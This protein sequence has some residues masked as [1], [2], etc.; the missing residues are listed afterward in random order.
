MTHGLHKA[1][2]LCAHHSLTLNRLELG[3]H[4]PQGQ[5]VAHADVL[6]SSKSAVLLSLAFTD[7]LRTFKEVMGLK[8]QVGGV[9]R[10]LACSVH[11][12]KVGCSTCSVAAGCAHQVNH[13]AALPSPCMQDRLVYLRMHPLFTGISLGDLDC[14]AEALHRAFYPAG[15]LLL[16]SKHGEPQ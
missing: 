4:A 14:L 11:G 7:F 13:N 12:C 2:L 15:T 5:A 6:V 16:P 10:L 1:G 8:Q 3:F 9:V